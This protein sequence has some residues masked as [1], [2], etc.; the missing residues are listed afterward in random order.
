MEEEKKEES[1][2]EEE[3]K[4]EEKKEEGTKKETEQ[5]PGV[6]Q[7]AEAVGIAQGMVGKIGSLIGGIF[8]GFSKGKR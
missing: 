4:E 3:K 2:E 1:K 6:E 5:I 7:A 8:G